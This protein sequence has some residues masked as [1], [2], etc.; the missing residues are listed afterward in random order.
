MPISAAEARAV[1]DRSIIVDGHCDAPYRMF[2]HNVRLGDRDPGG[3]H[4]DLRSLRDGGT[5]A[6]FFAA[7]VPP[8]YAGNGAAK[9]AGTLIDLIRE[10]AERY[11]E[12]VMFADSVAGIRKAKE[13]EKLALMI[14]IEGGH[15]IEDS[16]EKLHAFY[17]RGVRYMTL[18]HVNTNNWADSSGDAPRHGGLTDFGREVVRTMNAIGMI[19]DVSHVADTTFDDVLETT[20]VPVVASHSSC[21]ALAPHPRNLDD[22]MLGDLARNG[23]VCMINFYSAFV[24]RGAAE[25]LMQAK[26]PKQAPAVFNDEEDWSGF[27]EWYRSIG[28]PR[29]TLDEVVDHIVHAASIAGI[30]HVGIGSDFDGVPE[31]PEK[32]G[33]AG[34]LP[35]LTRRMLERDFR[36]AEVRKVL[37]ENFMRAFSAIERK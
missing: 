20:R 29:A 8:A 10:E 30:D 6:S 13:R 19:V 21:R 9:F 11:P 37:G 17:Q 36:E 26:R 22:R 33:D 4:A 1:H 35:N 25:M 12:D 16:L 14:G 7:Y 34:A 24:S 32:L 28:C 2:R 31:L 27:E 5:T 3:A 18:T 23:G 15:A